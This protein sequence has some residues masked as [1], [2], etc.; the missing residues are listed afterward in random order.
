MRCRDCHCP[1]FRHIHEP[2][3]VWDAT[4]RTHVRVCPSCA[5]TRTVVEEATLTPD[6]AAFLTNLCHWYPIDP[7]H[8][9]T[10]MPDPDPQPF[11]SDEFTRVL[12]TGMESL[13]PFLDAADG[14]RADLSR[15]GWQPATVEAIAGEWLLN[16]F[17]MVWRHS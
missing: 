1:F 12:M 16:T 7:T 6:Q 13:Q 8:L 15:R 2:I 4:L 3:T 17:R 9:E 11:D 14:L 5:E 10:P